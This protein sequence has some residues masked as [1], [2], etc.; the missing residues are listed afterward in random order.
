[1]L[2]E[3][4]CSDQSNGGHIRELSQNSVSWKFYDHCLDQSVNHVQIFMK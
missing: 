1:M 2:N 4:V 3:K